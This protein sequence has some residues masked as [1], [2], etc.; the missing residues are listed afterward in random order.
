M[1]PI[2]PKIASLALLAGL[3]L[4]VASSSWAQEAPPGA[5]DG[6]PPGAMG[7]P[8]P[9]GGR[10]HRP[11]PPP[12]EDVL[13]R[14]AGR[15]GLDE[16]TRSRIRAVVDGSRDE[17]RRLEDEARKLRGELRT[18][19]EAD[20]PRLDDV[21]AKA[22]AVGAA[23]TALHKQRLR[24][25]LGIRALLTPEQRAELV[26]IH[27]EMRRNRGKGM[28]PGGPPPGPGDPDGG[29]PPEDR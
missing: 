13:E 29:P 20:A 25:L 19:L 4:S 23:E 28:P 2:A 11:G 24:I 6:R 16:A 18:L 15:L 12:F 5:P 8:P 10:G 3:L 21:L 27:G 1:S 14:H 22:D 17:K 7:G 9:P 26:K